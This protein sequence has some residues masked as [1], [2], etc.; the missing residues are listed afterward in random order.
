MK[1]AY[2]SGISEAIDFLVGLLEYHTYFPASLKPDEFVK[3]VDAFYD[4]P[5]NLPI[6][7]MQ[8]MRIVTLKAN[9]ED[10]A[11]IDKEIA[12]LRRDAIALQQ[13]LEKNKK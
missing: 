1:L 2:V 4:Q 6:P 3:A 13:Q 12:G 5:E 8:A 10:P 11:A 7:I 9:G